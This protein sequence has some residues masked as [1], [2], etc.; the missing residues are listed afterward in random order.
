MTNYTHS[1]KNIIRICHFTPNGEKIYERLSQSRDISF[2]EK[3]KDQTLEDW[4]REGFQSRRPIVFISACGIAVRL[5][6]P[7]INNK[8]TDSP[9]IVIDELGHHIIPILSGHVGQGNSIAKKLA[10][11]LGGE[12]VITTATD[13]ENKFAAD[14]FATKN[15]L[16]IENKDGIKKV[17]S[18][19]LRDEKVTLSISPAARNYPKWMAFEATLSEEL[20]SSVSIVPFPTQFCDIRIVEASECNHYVDTEAQNLLLSFEVDLSQEQNGISANGINQNGINQMSTIYIVGMGPGCRE[21]MTSEAIE[22]IRQSDVVIGYT[23]YVDLMKEIFPGKPYMTTPMRQEIERCRMCFEEARAGKTVSLIC[24]GDAGVYGMAA[25]MY[26]LMSEYDDYPIDIQVV[27]GI[28]AA[29]SGAAL[30]GAPLN[31]DYCVISLSDLLTPFEQIEKRIRAAITGDFCMAIYNPSSHKRRDYLKRACEIMLEAG[32]LET[33]ACG[34]VK[35]IGRDNTEIQTLSLSELMNTSVDMFTTVFIGN[36]NT[37]IIDGK[38]VTP[39]GYNLSST[40]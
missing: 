38:L 21:N 40:H 1:G 5:I 35:N 37:R 4:T 31:H 26:E 20:P 10:D 18:K 33:R 13:L 22:A 8:L 17:S 34:Y 6:A 3:P 29:N 25:P 11:I 32:A 14:I 24:S 27:S 9:V 15:G 30:L 7:Y 39:R 19:I 23:V 12:A 36:S 28:T 2:E 16:V